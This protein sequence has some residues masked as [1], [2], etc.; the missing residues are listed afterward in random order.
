MKNMTKLFE[1][2][3]ELCKKKKWKRDKKGIVD[4]IVLVILLI[5]MGAYSYCMYTDQLL[6][7]II[8]VTAVLFSS[9]AFLYAAQYKNSKILHRGE[10]I[11]DEWYKEFKALL[12]K[13]GIITDEDIQNLKEWCDTVS[14]INSPTDELKIKIEKALSIFVIPAAISMTFSFSDIIM[15]NVLFLVLSTLI[16]FLVYIGLPVFAKKNERAI[17]DNMRL[18]LIEFKL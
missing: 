12:T 4:I 8:A 3:N 6:Y 13:H 10:M 16:G 11:S 14:T 5:S 18:D 15:V 17:I 2:Y 7:G 1:E 9:F